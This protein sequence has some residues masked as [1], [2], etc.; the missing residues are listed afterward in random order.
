MTENAE[1]VQPVRPMTEKLSDMTTSS[2]VR[3]L[4]SYVV[5]LLLIWSLMQ[6]TVYPLL[7]ALDLHNS[8]IF[9]PYFSASTIAFA[10]VAAVYFVFMTYF[11]NQ[12]IGKMIFGIKVMSSSGSKL[13]MTQVLYREVVG[14]FIN[15][16]AFY[17]PYLMILFTE[18]RIGLHDFFSDTYV[19]K[20]RFV[21]YETEIRQSM[22]A[23]DSTITINNY[24]S[25]K[26]EK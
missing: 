20:E 21:R 9:V 2:F 8:Y 18:R 5:D 24:D 6:L 23:S 11:F 12:T 25:M 22:S 15:N 3:R 13:S 10:L 16:S 19:A 1:N 14:R 26:V 7:N 4:I 17:I